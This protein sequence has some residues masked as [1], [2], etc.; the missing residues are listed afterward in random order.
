MVRYRLTPSINVHFTVSQTHKKFPKSLP[1]IYYT[2]VATAD[3]QLTNVMLYIEHTSVPSSF[4]HR[5]ITQFDALWRSLPNKYDGRPV[6]KSL[7]QDGE[8]GG[9]GPL[10]NDNLG[11]VRLS[12][13][14]N[15]LSFVRRFIGVQTN[16]ISS[17]EYASGPRGDEV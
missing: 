7:R 13:G 5:K 3:E 10:F 4:K 12:G 6:R 16:N 14:G 2:T 11:I 15:A 17:L 9:P 1:E 8:S